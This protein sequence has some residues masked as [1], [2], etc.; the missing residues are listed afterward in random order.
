MLNIANRCSIVLA[1][2]FFNSF[3]SFIRRGVIR[4]I[5]SW[6]NYETVHIDARWEHYAGSLINKEPGSLL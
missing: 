3:S 4:G 6:S 5:S 1:Y 2:H